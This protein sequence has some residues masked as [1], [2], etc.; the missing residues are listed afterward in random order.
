MD[1][2][3]MTPI[4]ADYS[5]NEFNS[6]TTEGY[7]IEVEV[8][9]FDLG[10][11]LEL[12]NKMTKYWH[13]K[14]DGSLRNS[15][16]EFVSK[17]LPPDDVATAVHYLYGKTRKH[18]EPSER[19]GIHVHANMLGRTFDEVARICTYYAMVEPLVFLWAGTEREENIFCVPWYRAPDEAAL[20]S[21]ALR[22]GDM[23]SLRQS[24]KYSGLFAGPLRTFG[25]LEFRHARTFDTPEQLEAWVRVIRMT[26]NAYTLPDP[27]ELYAQEGVAAV[28]K[29][30]F[31]EL[32]EQIN[33]P[34]SALEALLH[35]LGAV[36]TALLF[37]PVTYA[38]SGWGVPC[39]FDVGEGVEPGPDLGSWLPTQRFATLDNEDGDEDELPE[40]DEDDEIY[41]EPE[42]EASDEEGEV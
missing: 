17:F 1:G 13:I 23:F 4:V 3:T 8:E 32:Y 10:T 20:V 33:M 26:A 6:P 21:R 39:A 30:L 19:T 37:Q 15:G 35:D 31:G 24:C 34:D 16:A 9:R 5:A 36:E 29:L 40:Y 14:D 38:Q 41:D 7:G 18:W 27:I 28:V 25:T 11:R 42:P 12:A 2:G 22:S